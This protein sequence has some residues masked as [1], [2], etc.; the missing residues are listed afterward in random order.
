M[1]DPITPK[2]LAQEIGVSD[3][4]VRVFLRGRYGTLPPFVTR[5]HLT[6][7]Q[8]AEVRAHFGGLSD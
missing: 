6:E 1:E 8:A 2:S 5:W 7:V 4:A 3:R